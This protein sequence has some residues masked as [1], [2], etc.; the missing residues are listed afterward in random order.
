[1]TLLQVNAT[2]TSSIAKPTGYNATTSAY[3][4]S[5]PSAPTFNPATVN[6]SATPSVC[7][8]CLQGNGAV[9]EH[10]N[11]AVAAVAG[12]AALVWGSL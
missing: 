11:L 12:A 8:N 9:S 2:V 10:V 3:T 4:A 5:A 7:A 6:P 1:M